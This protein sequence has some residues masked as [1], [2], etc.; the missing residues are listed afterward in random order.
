MLE[1]DIN[2]L[3]IDEKA[4][5]AEKKNALTTAYRSQTY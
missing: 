5:S 2:T 3:L 4:L 1:D